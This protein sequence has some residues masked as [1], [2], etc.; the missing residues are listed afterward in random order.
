MRRRLSRILSGD[1]A[2]ANE[3][4]RGG[5]ILLHDGCDLMMGA[6]R[7]ASVEATRQL[8]TRF[9]REGRRMVTVDAA[10]DQ[11]GL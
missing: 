1:L 6:D 8:L 9:N 10:W 3:R 5:N 7:D 11:R 4:G 2:Y